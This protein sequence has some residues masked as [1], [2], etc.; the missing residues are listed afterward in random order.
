MTDERAIHIA[1]QPVIGKRGAEPWS[2]EFADRLFAQWHDELNRIISD[3]FRLPPGYV[4]QPLPDIFYQRLWAML[5]HWGTFDDAPT[6]TSTS[7]YPESPDI[8]YH[9]THRHLALSGLRPGYDHLRG[10]DDGG[11]TVVPEMLPDLWDLGLPER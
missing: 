6:A 8:P 10:A 11:Q 5:P 9:R 3:S 7:V 4:M 1:P 2:H